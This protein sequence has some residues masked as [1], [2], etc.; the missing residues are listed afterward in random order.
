MHF[1]FRPRHVPRA[2]GWTSDKV[3]TFIVTLAATR[4][5]TLAAHAA[6]MSRKS[7][8]ALRARD[9]AFAKGWMAAMKAGEQGLR[10]P[11]LSLS[12]GDKVEEVEAPRGGHAGGMVDNGAPPFHPVRVTRHP[13]GPSVNA[14]EG[15]LARLRESAPL[16]PR[17]AAQ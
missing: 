11:A 6:A 2:G 9:S 3:V 16:A 15:L 1:L 5:V 4:S 8:Y 7:A 14:F 17:P 10:G 12:K 13:R